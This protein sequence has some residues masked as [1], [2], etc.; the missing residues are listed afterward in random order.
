MQQEVII[1]Y[2]HINYANRRYFPAI[3]NFVRRKT[4][5][6]GRHATFPVQAH[7]IKACQNL[8]CVVL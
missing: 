7:L 2:I 4:A 1:T 3:T 8:V 6:C 5:R